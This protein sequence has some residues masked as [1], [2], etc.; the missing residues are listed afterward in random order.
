MNINLDALKASGVYTFEYDASTTISE[1]S[2]YGRLLIGSSK[3]GPFNTIVKINT[4]AQ[5]KNIYGSND[6]MLEK[7]GS[8]FHKSL[9][10]LL[11]EGPVYALN[12]LPID[13]TSGPGNT[14]RGSIATINTECA[15]VNN[16]SADVEV[17]KLFNR[18]K[19]WYASDAELNRTK[20]NTSTLDKTHVLS[21]A[22]TSQRT[23]TVFVMKGSSNGYDITVNEWYAALGANVEVPSYL[24]PDDYISDFIVRVVV[25]DGDWTNYR[26]LAADPVFSKYFTTTGLKTSTIGEFLQLKT[27]NVI[28][29]VEGSIIPDF[30]DNT[31]TIISID[32][33]FNNM[34]PISQMVCAID[35]DNLDMIDLTSGTYNNT[36]VET[37][38]L[39]LVGHGLL[40]SANYID[41]DLTANNV[42]IIDTLSYRGITSNTLKYMVSTAATP[43]TATLIKSYLI[44]G[45][46]YG[47]RAYQDSNL[48][49][50]YEYG[51]LKNGDT[52]GTNK[53]LKIEES[54]DASLKVINISAYSDAQL[55]TLTTLG[56]DGDDITITVSSASD[57]S[58]VVATNIFDSY[59]LSKPNVLKLDVT[60][61][62]EVGQTPDATEKKAY[63][64]SKEY[65]KVGN[66]IKVAVTDGRP[67]M[68]RITKVSKVKEGLITFLY[69]E[70]LPSASPSV[71]GIDISGNKFIVYKS[72]SK[73]V[74]TLNGTKMIPFAITSDLLPNGS[75][76]ESIMST[77]FTTN[78]AQA[79]SES[80]AIDI[81]YIVDS[82]KGDIKAS[83]K[84]NLSKLAATHGQAMLFTN[85][86]SMKEF[87]NSVD[88]SFIDITSGGIV[89]VEYISEGGN[90]ALNPSYTFA[91]GSDTVNGVPIESFAHYTFP[92]LVINDDGKE[93]LMIPSP[94]TC[95]AY[96]KKFKAN[97]PYTIIAGNAGRITD[98]DVLGVE[99]ELTDSDRG[100]LEP[101][102]YNLL[103]K[104]RK[105]G[106]M[107][108]TNNTAY[109]R[110]KSALNNAHVRDTL[111]TIEKNIENILFNFLFKYNTPI[112]RSRVYTLIDNYLEGV[113]NNNGIAGY[114][115]QIDENNNDTYILENNSAVLD[116]TVDFNRGIHKFINKITVTRPGG[117]L[118]IAQS[119]FSAV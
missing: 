74:T 37:K 24:H 84:Y 92:N 110:V 58:N 36:D 31:G 96:I 11:R 53:Y 42:K 48:Y 6:K 68:S 88:P 38:R 93:K 100:L 21:F 82:Y 9:E 114:T 64:I 78:I 77:L 67:R 29:N 23:T 50:L 102:G 46:N 98:F 32:R 112:T 15:D 14:H 57:Y 104:K 118:S 2:E 20:N 91:F 34:F 106:V 99:Y 54:T 56:S 107:L 47:V 30:K 35:A 63:D 109:N 94:Y 73:Q 89:N 75:N 97:A 66:Y 81:R 103:V 19:L 7:K 90:L 51:F 26:K 25:V 13:T 113:F 39:D 18:Q 40:D 33:K 87:E 3:K 8:Y 4:D 52:A 71:E 117:Q 80:D 22:N 83:S 41:V 76:Q 44:G 10:I 61:F 79:I 85:A 5:A 62:E 70:T 119:G 69:I 101:K 12:V 111:I 86:P 43:V 28:V 49:K 55:T 17:F 115:I 45:S 27:T 105:G 59:E 16:A 95:N 60:Q 1:V 72:L 108:F 116:V 65:I